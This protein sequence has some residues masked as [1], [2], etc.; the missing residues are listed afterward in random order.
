MAG[1]NV[2]GS[3]SGDPVT[4]TER[5]R[6]THRSN[7]NGGTLVTAGNLVVQGTIDSRLEIYAADSGRPLWRYDTQNVPISGAISWSIATSS[8][9][10]SMA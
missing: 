9:V 2:T 1:S 4:Q 8:M 10:R 5:W 3:P 6:V 7:G